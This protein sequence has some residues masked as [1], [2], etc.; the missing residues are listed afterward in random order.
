MT[1][2]LENA[3]EIVKALPPPEREKFFDWVEE[4][5]QS[6][7]SEKETISRELAQKNEKFRRALQWIE[8]HKKEYDG[9]FVLLEGDQLIA[10]SKSPKELYT[11]ARAKGISV[12]FVKRIKAK[13]LPFGGW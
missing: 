2:T 1:P 6:E 7:Q 13:D 4:E 10:H 9:Q 12:P 5:K 8:E 3:I 11:T